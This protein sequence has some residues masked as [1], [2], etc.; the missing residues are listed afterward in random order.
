MH[1]GPFGQPFL[2]AFSLVAMAPLL[3]G[4]GLRRGLYVEA[5]ERDCSGPPETS[6]IRVSPVIR[7]ELLSGIVGDVRRAR[8]TAEGTGAKGTPGRNRGRGEKGGFL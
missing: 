8:Q 1:V 3:R 6:V 7:K 4:L 5:L 2:E